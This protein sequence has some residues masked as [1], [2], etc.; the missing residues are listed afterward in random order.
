MIEPDY[1]TYRKQLKCLKPDMTEQ[2]IYQWY[3][4]VVEGGWSVQS[5]PAIG[6]DGQYHY[7]YL[8]ERDDGRI[9]VGKHSTDDLDDGYQGSGYDIT[10]GK[11][12]G[13]TFTTTKLAF[14][15]TAD[16]AYV[17]EKNIVNGAYLRSGN[18]MN[19]VEG[20][21]D[22]CKPMVNTIVDDK[23]NT[24]K[25]QEEINAIASNVVSTTSSNAKRP[26]IAAPGTK[27]WWSFY[28]LKL[29]DGYVLTFVDD[30]TKTCKIANSKTVDCGDGKKVSLYSAAV[31]YA[32][33]VA[34][35]KNALNAFKYKDR[36]LSEIRD[37][38]ASK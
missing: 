10:D 34:K 9:Y 35:Y 3:M 20:G 32:G 14:F 29:H 30:K 16:Q 7:I 38:I 2:E 33:G 36:L 23:F 18:C 31:K 28:D 12:L 5:K 6:D 11:N 27:R 4:G 15:R 17:A 21:K 13:R 25:F 37:E 26:K 24:M 19:M 8:T 22:Y 1:S